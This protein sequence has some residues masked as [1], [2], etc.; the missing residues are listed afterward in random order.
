[1]SEEISLSGPPQDIHEKQLASIKALAQP[2]TKYIDD[3]IKT[4]SNKLVAVASPTDATVE[5][6]LARVQKYTRISKRDNTDKIL[7]EMLKELSPNGQRNLTK[8]IMDRSDGSLR[9][10]AQEIKRCIFTPTTQPNSTPAEEPTNDTTK[11]TGS[12]LRLKQLCLLRDENKCVITGVH[13]IGATKDMMMA[14]AKNQT[15]VTKCTRVIP[16]SI[17]P[18]RSDGELRDYAKTWA[19]I[20]RYF[21]EFKLAIDVR[22]PGMINS[23]RN[24][25]TL[26]EPIQRAFVD[27]SLALKPIGDCRYKIITYNGSSAVLDALPTD[28]EIELQTDSNVELPDLELLG[29]HYAIANV[30]HAAGLSEQIDQDIKIDESRCLR[31]DG[32]ADT[33]GVLA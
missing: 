1:M 11:V 22:R 6:A 25:V 3:P 20:Y 18:Q 16:S 32:S 17:F 2:E 30:L 12:Q 24:S 27:F 5:D 8:D 13:D 31:H 7:S 29:F 28:R 14:K 4:E 9:D 19:L 23:P 33:G 21:P 15:T 10:H 26:W